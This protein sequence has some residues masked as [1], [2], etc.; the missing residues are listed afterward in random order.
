MGQL[1]NQMFQYATLIGIAE[2]HGYEVVLP[3][4]N[5]Q[6]KEAEQDYTGK[7]ISYGLS[8]LDCFDLPNR[9]LTT[10]ELNLSIQYQYRE[11]HH[12][13]DEN[14]LRVPDNTG[15]IGHFE[16]YRYF[17]HAKKAVL[18]KLKFKPEIRSRAEERFKERQNKPVVSLHV[19]THTRYTSEKFDHHAFLPVEYYT[20]A[21][22]FFP[23][24]VYDVLVFTDNFP[25]VKENIKGPNI[26]YND[27]DT[28][29]KRP[30]FIDLC[31]MSLCD[32]HIVAN[33]S[34]SWWGAYLADKKDQVIIA[35]TQWF[36]PKFAHMS[37]ID[38]VPPSWI[39]V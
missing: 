1:G 26:Y 29:Y 34:F 12:E 27:W 21:L 14:A 36:G 30:D 16:S 11:A 15:L 23:E 2:K 32:H 17:D 6:I 13:F 22:K 37:S 20:N 35:P 5:R 38:T 10:N 33:S 4:D 19:R 3:G 39:R 25:W 28:Q 31:M 8:L 24:Q 7:K 9:V 18:D